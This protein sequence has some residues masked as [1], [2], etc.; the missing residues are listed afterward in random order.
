[1]MHALGW[2]RVRLY[3]DFLEPLSPPDFHRFWLLVQRRARGEPLQYITGH[4][5]FWGLD[6]KVTPAV[7]IPRPETELL[8]EEAVRRI[9][10]AWGDTEVWLAD[11]GTGSGCIA[12]ALARELPGARVVATDVSE[13]ALRVARENALLHHVGDRIRFYQGH[14]VD[15]LRSNFARRLNAVVSNPP[16]VLP[17][18]RDTL[19]VDVR[20]HEPPEALLTDGKLSHYQELIG[21][22]PELLVPGGLLLLEM[23]SGQEDRIRSFLQVPGWEVMETR[24]DLQGIPRCLVARHLG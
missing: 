6:F 14:M 8:V 10:G 22:A 23:G 3:R 1:M 5:E 18:E 20:D 24:K 12:V 19:G 16:Y 4:Q 13:A 11:V 7:L 17:Q 9:R 21:M 2:E 15:P